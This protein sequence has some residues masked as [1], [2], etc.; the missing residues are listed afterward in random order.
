ME[1]LNPNDFADRYAARYAGRYNDS[2]QDSD[3]KHVESTLSMSSD[4]ISLETSSSIDSAFT[5]S[6]SLDQLVFR[7]D[8]PSYGT[9][10]DSKLLEGTDLPSEKILVRRVYYLAACYCVMFMG[11]GTAQNQLTN[12]FPSLGNISLVI[13]YGSGAVSAWFCGAIVT[14]IGEKIVMIIAALI[15]AGFLGAAIPGIPWLFLAMSACA[16]FVSGPL[17][18]AQGSYLGKSTS[19][20]PQAIGRFNAAFGM[21][22]NVNG[23]LG[24]LTVA[25]ITTFQLLR[26]PNG[27]SGLSGSTNLIILGILAGMVALSSVLFIFLRQPPILDSD[28]RIMNPNFPVQKQSRVAKGLFTVG[29]NIAEM[30]K[31][32]IDRKM[33]FLL[34]YIFY[35]GFSPA[36]LWGGLAPIFKSALPAAHLPLPWVFVTYASAT[37]SSSF[38]WGRLWDKWGWKP[39]LAIN[40]FLQ[41]AA[42]VLVPVGWWFRSIIPFFFAA[43]IMGANETLIGTVSTATLLKYF[44]DQPAAAFSVCR[45]LVSTGTLLCFVTMTLVKDMFYITQAII[46][47]SFLIS[48]VLYIIKFR[49]PDHSIEATTS[50]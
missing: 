44:P 33:L 22:Y 47:A 29:K 45:F 24:N 10:E 40:A 8:S 38:L 34:S 31:L 3:L 13:F 26:N 18:V 1:V 36:F 15:T 28:E 35:V 49:E 12:I 43:F 5:S 50:V 20:Y 11:Y 6:S 39:L 16:G 48:S 21:V 25:G 37:L 9:F 30:A 4:D 14:L 41:V 27:G 32:L 17:W 46:C 42:M 23:I 19:R 2:I 7:S